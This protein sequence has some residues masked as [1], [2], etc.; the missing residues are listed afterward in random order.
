MSSYHT[1]IFPGS[2]QN[3][4]IS[5]MERI[6]RDIDEPIQID[7]VFTSESVLSNIRVEKKSLEF[8]VE[9]YIR[10]QDIN[11]HIELIWL[12]EKYQ[13]LDDYM[14]ED[15]LKGILTFADTINGAYVAEGFEAMDFCDQFIEIDGTRHVDCSSPLFAESNK[16]DTIYINGLKGGNIPNDVSLKYL[17]SVNTWEKYEISYHF[18]L[19]AKSSVNLPKV[20]ISFLSY[21]KAKEIYDYYISNS[22]TQRDKNALSHLSEKFKLSEKIH[23]SDYFFL[24]LG[25]GQAQL[26][27]NSVERETISA[28]ENILIDCIER[29]YEK[30]IDAEILSMEIPKISTL[31]HFLSLRV[32]K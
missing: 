5:M 2:K 20:A 24:W 30:V 7:H 13:F 16:V 21:N 8:T 10:H 22:T 15:L 32:K 12:Y 31:I 19:T 27:T 9:I 11:P 1:Y 17:S 29:E 3:F 25:L 23:S 4:D 28:I 6:F 14:K 18:D 26:E